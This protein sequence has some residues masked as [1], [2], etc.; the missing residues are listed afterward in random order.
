MGEAVAIL[1]ASR[2]TDACRLPGFVV[3]LVVMTSD[4]SRIRARQRAKRKRT[5]DFLHRTPDARDIDRAI[6]RGLASFVDQTF[7]GDPCAIRQ[8]TMTLAI[9]SCIE[10]ELV[11]LDVDTTNHLTTS[12]LRRRLHIRGDDL[13]RTT[14]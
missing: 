14:I 9:L 7:D 5:L 12:R 10:G 1:Y 8:S 2:V 3:G 4:A 13:R 11:R 6:S